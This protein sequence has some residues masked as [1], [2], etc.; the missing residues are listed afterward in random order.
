MSAEEVRRRSFATSF[1]GFDQSEVRSF[2]DRM[3]DELAA[4]EAAERQLREELRQAR[5]RLLHPRLDEDTLTSALGEEAAK[6]LRSAHEAAADVR[7]RAEE[8]AARMLAEAHAEAQ[9]IRA[10]AETVLAERTAEAEAEVSALRRAAEVS[11]AEMVSRAQGQAETALAEVR[12]ASDAMAE[13]ADQLKVQVL[14]DLAQRRRIMNAQVEQLA[15][16]RDS[17]LRA[18]HTV[19]GFLDEIVGTLDSAEGDAKRAAAEALQRA[20]ARS[21]ADMEELEREIGPSL[22]APMALLAEVSS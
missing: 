5:D 9:R 14:G 19:R 10:T 12:S 13:E 3:A 15:A 20:L 6:I 8:N 22:A 4:A 21:E 18:V 16:G 7:G 1:R 17:I 11:V 2:L